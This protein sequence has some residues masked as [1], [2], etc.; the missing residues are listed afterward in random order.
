MIRLTFRKKRS[1]LLAAMLIPII[2]IACR[3]TGAG[4]SPSQPYGN[5]AFNTAAAKEWFYGTFKKSKEFLDM[6]V[7]LN[8][9]KLP[10]WKTGRYK[11][12][13]N[14]EI[15]EFDL[16]E[17]IKGVLLKPSG[18]QFNDRRIAEAA[19]NRAVFIKTGNAIQLELVMYIPELNYLAARGYDISENGVLN[20]DEQ[21]TGKVLVTRWNGNLVKGY[22]VEQGK[23]MN[24]IKKIIKQSARNGDNGTLN[25]SI[26]PDCYY[27]Y[28]AWYEQ[29][30]TI[31]PIGDNIFLENCDNW[32]LIWDYVVE[33]S[34]PLDT[35]DCAAMGL[36][37]EDCMCQ[38]LGL[39]GDGEPDPSDC[40]NANLD[41]ILNN[42]SVEA[43][44]LPRTATMIN[45]S[46]ADMPIDWRV[47][48][49][50]NGIGSTRVYSHEKANLKMN[51]ALN[52]WKFQ[53]IT[54][55]G[56]SVESGISAYDCEATT[57]G[58]NVAYHDVW[59]WNY[60]HTAIL[61]VKYN[62]KLTMTCFATIKISQKN[63]E[64]VSP[65]IIPLP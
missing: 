26:N 11:K 48:T 51:T 42:A 38:M 36:S 16:V 49:I 39:C 13:G 10:E 53:D 2:Y 8:G 35:S 47:F 61:K 43:E 32:E 54:H 22:N 45:D 65:P 44:M 60:Y 57:I 12:M 27:S 9:K 14:M 46:S 21:F 23:K 52:R 55:N 5:A 15:V 6:P 31:T 56:L 50:Q 63:Y 17:Q 3:K 4:E 25:T 7:A 29:N 1:I 24:V 19:I 62:V 41:E 20:P 18:N 30:C 33:T 59:A 37:T 64:T 28:N 58:F 34:C 40:A